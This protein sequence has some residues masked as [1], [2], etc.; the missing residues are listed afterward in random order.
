VRVR[1]FRCRQKALPKLPQRVRGT[2]LPPVWFQETQP[3]PTINVGRAGNLTPAQQ[4][5]ANGGR[6]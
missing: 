5:R 1:W 2:N 4:F 6:W 3:L